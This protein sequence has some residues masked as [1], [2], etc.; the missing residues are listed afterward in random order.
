MIR[1]LTVLLGLFIGLSALAN[2]S[3]SPLVRLNIVSKKIRGISI[4]IVERSA[5]QKAVENGTFEDFFQQRLEDYLASDE[6]SKK[7]SRRLEEL[8]RFH[9]GLNALPEVVEDYIQKEGNYEY[10]PRLYS[11]NNAAN[12]MF[13]NLSKKNLSWDT[14]LTGKDYRAYQVRGNNF[15]SYSDWGFL[16]A[17]MPQLATDNGVEY[18]TGETQPNKGP[19]VFKDVNFSAKD[20]R[21][22]GVITTGRFFNRYVNTG[23]NKNRKRAAAI[24]RVFLCDGMS[25]AIPSSAGKEDEIYD[26]MFPHKS[27]TEEDLIKS[28][29]ESD[30]IH[31]N[32]PDCMKCHYKLDPMGKTLL[33]SQ[34]ILS[35]KAGKGHLRYKKSDGS[36]VDIPVKGVGELATAISQQNEYASCQVRHFWNW[37]MPDSKLSPEKETQLIAQFNQVGRRTNDFLKFIIAQPEFYSPRPSYTEDQ[38]LAKNVRTFLKRCQDCHKDQTYSDSPDG[39]FP[40]FTVWPIGGSSESMKEWSQMIYRVMDLTHDGENPRM[41]PSST[42]WR[43][44]YKEAQVI[45][46]WIDKGMPDENGKLMG[47]KEIKL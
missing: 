32:E 23:L 4:S 26:L 21:I 18:Q 39:R 1:I 2:P 41:P 38:L 13:E 43:T 12:F 29:N 8:F 10:N 14:L 27:Y 5:A 28:M 17:V 16:S 6:H 30:S 7:M 47:K 19:L 35:P 24:F 20:P 11:D 34:T 44:S 46:T 45:K 40:D 22:A 37:F 9:G 42:S 36:M 33:T 15:F 25:A 31:G 3:V